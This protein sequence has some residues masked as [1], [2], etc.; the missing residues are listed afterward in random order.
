[1][2]TED[3][4][5]QI[6]HFCNSCISVRAGET[7]LMCD[8]WIGPADTNA[9]LSYPF[10][11]EGKA[12]IRRLEPDFIY[13]SHLHP[14]HHDPKT[15]EHVARDT[16]IIIKN[17]PDHRLFRKLEAQGFTNVIEL[18]AWSPLTLGEDLEIAIVPATSM[19]NKAIEAT[20][21]YDIDTSLLVRSLRT[22]QVFYNNVDNPTGLPALNQ[23]REFS[24]KTWGRPVDIAC[25]P[26]GA[27]SEYPHCFINIDR[28]AAA[29]RIIDSSLDEL[30]A[31][32]KALGCHTFFAAG[33][34]YVVRGKF[35]A[36]NRYIG[37]PTFEEIRSF[38]AAQ[39]NT[40]PFLH[41][42]EGGRGVV[43][44][45]NSNEWRACE[46]G[47]EKPS[48][49]TEYALAS[50]PMDYD[51]S[52]DCRSGA[53]SAEAAVAR[54]RAALEGALENQK[55]VM[56]RIGLVQDWTNE[57]KLYQNL[58]LDE[59]GNIAP[60][61]TAID[62]VTLSCKKTPLKQT[63]SFHMDIDLFTDLLEGRG[64]WN[65]ALSGTYIIYEREPDFFLPDAPFC[66]NFLV[67]RSHI[68][69]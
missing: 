22:G 46:T 16:T 27:A 66:M 24:E 21:H 32:I 62:H 65:G 56:E 11:E 50:T 15:L 30:P 25:L 2:A 4:Q 13:I 61:Q 29:K 8:P 57:I 63:L 14:D 69:E 37:Q 53:V 26:V 47:F 60:G 48:N 58:R 5:V 67:D 28:E 10:K 7:S 39:P 19:V 23:V 43:F 55:N 49:K 3:E 51:Y 52:T 38:L 40:G 33:G 64:N 20:I 34:T 17:F 1:M 18:G 44:D 68:H 35:S 12:I 41:S 42:L 45:E 54:M 31:R 59:D 9:W 6:T 36:L